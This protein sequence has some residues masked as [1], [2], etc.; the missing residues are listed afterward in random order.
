MYLHIGGNHVIDR[1]DIIGVFD[2]E[3]STVSN[4]T[5]DY[6]RKQEKRGRVIT[7]VSD[8]PK[9]FIIV[10]KDSNTYVY[11]SSIAPITLRKRYEGGED[12]Y[13]TAE[14]R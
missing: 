10:E 11:L 3:K 7:I 14:E 12:S 5:R 9:S 2:I 1:R 13:T 4:I 6:L 8:M